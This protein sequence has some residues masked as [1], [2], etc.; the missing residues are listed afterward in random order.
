[1]QARISASSACLWSVVG[2][3]QGDLVDRAEEF[4]AD[5]DATA[6]AE[7]GDDL[8]GGEVARFDP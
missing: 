1:M 6:L 3:S 4:G 5:D 8:V 2:V 7:G